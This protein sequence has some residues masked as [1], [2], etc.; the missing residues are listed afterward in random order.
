LASARRHARTRP[1]PR[2]SH[3][4]RWPRARGSVLCSGK[5][6][7]DQPIDATGRCPRLARGLINAATD[8]AAAT[9]RQWLQ[10][11]TFGHRTGAA[12]GIR[13]CPARWPSQHRPRDSSPSAEPEQA[14]YDDP[15][16]I[17]SR[18]R[19]NRRGTARLARGSH[20]TEAAVELLIRAR[21]GRFVEP[22]QPWLST[23]DR[24]ITWLDAQLVRQYAHAVSSGERHILALVEALALGGPLEDVGGLMASLDPLPSRS[25]LRVL[26]A[27]QLWQRGLAACR[28]F[29]S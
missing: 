12:Q 18:W 22:G 2:S 1:H 15:K 19:R 28:R 25:R 17:G 29:W 9:D 4:L 8:V 7:K 27:C 24:G 16:C 6:T 5:G 11:P 14:D 26:A 21:G 3:W 10:P 23:D 13:P 20:S